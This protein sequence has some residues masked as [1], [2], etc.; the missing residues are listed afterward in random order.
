[1][2]FS[3]NDFVTIIRQPSNQCVN[4]IGQ[5]GIIDKISGD[6]AQITAYNTHSDGSTSFGGGGAVPLSCL[7]INHDEKIKLDYKKHIIKQDNYAKSIIDYSNKFNQ[8]IEEI[9]KKYN[10]TSDDIKTIC[11]LIDNFEGKNNPYER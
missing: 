5:H 7:E 4:L 9:A 11:Q 10:L 3:V 8:Y 1:M 2:K 6:Y